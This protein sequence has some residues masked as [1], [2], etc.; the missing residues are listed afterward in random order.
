MHHLQLCVGARKKM[1]QFVQKIFIIVC[2]ERSI[3]EIMHN[4]DFYVQTQ[5]F[6]EKQ[7]L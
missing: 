7:Q 5:I 3:Y 6:R 2:D 1:F 4:D